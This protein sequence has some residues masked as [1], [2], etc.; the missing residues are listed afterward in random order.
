MYATDGLLCYWKQ[1]IKNCSFSGHLKF[2]PLEWTVQGFLSFSLF[3]SFLFCSL[4]SHCLEQCLEHSRCQK[5]FIAWKLQFQRILSLLFYFSRGKKK[6]AGGIKLISYME[7]AAS[8]IPTPCNSGNLHCNLKSSDYD[9]QPPLKANCN[10]LF[11]E[12]IVH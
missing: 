3:F 8:R 7:A 1:I 5:M 10:F 9:S 2:R 12:G 4:M 6:L 11:H